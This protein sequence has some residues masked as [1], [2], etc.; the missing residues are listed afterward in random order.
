MPDTWGTEQEYFLL[1]LPLINMVICFVLDKPMGPGNLH[2]NLALYELSEEDQLKADTLAR[3]EA[4]ELSQKM[5][6]EEA[7]A[8]RLR[9]AEGTSGASTR[10]DN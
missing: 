1:P 2:S 3:V 8:K 5:A 10:P 9:S 6:L 7:S 4:Y